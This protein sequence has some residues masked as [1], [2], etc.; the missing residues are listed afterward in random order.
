[1]N[2]IAIEIVQ[3]CLANKD[4]YL[5][6]GRLGLRDEDFVEGS[7]LDHLLRQCIHLETLVLSNEWDEW[8]TTKSK[9][10]QQ[11]SKN[12]GESNYFTT[13]PPALQTLKGLTGLI[14]AGNLNNRWAIVDM[15]FVAAL[16][17]L[18][19]LNLSYNQIMVI[20]GLDALTQLQSLYL[21]YNQIA[22]IR[23]LDAL[24]QLQ[25]L[26]LSSN[27]IADIKGL[28][29]L[30]QLQSLSLSSNG[31]TD[32]KGLEKLTQLQSLSLSS[33]GITDVKGLEKLTQLQSLYLSYNQITDIK[34]L[35]EPTQLQSLHLHNNQITDI[36]G[37]ASLT[38][39][40]S[41]SLYS[42]QITDIKGLEKLAQ[43]Q[44]LNLSYNQI[45]DIKGLENLTQLQLLYLHNN[46]ITNIKGLDTLTQ[47]QSLDLYSNQITDIKGLENLTQL[48]SLD[49]SYNQIIDI[50]GLEKLASLKELILS[51]NQITNIKGLDTLTQLQSLS[52][53]SNQITDI[54]G[55]EK[56]TQ[57]QSLSLSSNQI[58]DIMGLEKLTQL[59][60]LSLSSNQITDIK[61][62]DALTQLQSLGLSSNQITDIKGL[63]T[64]TALRSL[65]LSSNQIT[66]IRGLKKLPA[67]KELHLAYNQLTQSVALL[68]IPHL[69]RLS[70]I[71]NPLKDIPQELLVNQ[72]SGEDG[73]NDFHNWWAE[74][75]NGNNEPNQLAKL[76]L[77]GNG[78][79]GKSSLLEALA[80]GQCTTEHLSTNGIRILPLQYHNA[81]SDVFFYAWD[82]GGQEIYHGT[83]RLFIGSEAMQVIVTD[84][85]TEQCALQAQPVPDRILPDQL[86]QHLQLPHYI[87]LCQRYSRGSQLVVVQNKVDDGK[88]EK[89][90]PV[91]IIANKEG[92]AY[93][94]VSALHGNG[95]SILQTALAEARQ[96]LLHYGMVMPQSWLAVRDYFLANTS[97]LEFERIKQLRYTDFEAICNRFAVIQRST[98][99]LLKLLHHSGIVYTNKD[100][101]GDIIIT[102]HRW[103][104]DAI[105]APLDRGTEFYDAMMHD[106]KGRI[107]LKY[108]FRE[109]GD[110]YSISEKRLFLNFMQSCGLCFPLHESTTVEE[111]QYYI[112]PQFLP[113]KATP[114]IDTIWELAKKDIRTVFCTLPYLDYYRIQQFIIKLGHKT[115]LPYIWRE[116]ILVITKKG[117]FRVDADRRYKTIWVQGEHAALNHYL[118]DIIDAFNDDSYAHQPEWMEGGDMKS[119]SPLDLE[120]LKHQVSTSKR[121]TDNVAS[122]KIEQEI[123]NEQEE[124]VIKNPNRLDE[125]PNQNQQRPKR[126]VISYASEDRHVP[127]E[128]KSHADEYITNGKLELLFDKETED[129]KRNWHDR[130][131][132]IFDSAD[133]YL[134]LRSR[135]YQAAQQKKYIWQHEINKIE[136]RHQQEQIFTYCLCVQP[137]PNNERL[138]VFDKYN[139]GEVLPE[140]PGHKREQFLI[141]FVKQVI[142]QLFLGLKD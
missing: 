66:N 14:I 136:Q 65:Y 131:Q 1:M 120:T 126:L 134:I 33:N 103:A 106:W 100:L 20:Q 111:D 121:R 13:H 15:G 82:F 112:F 36:K 39:L 30:T 87:H 79:V 74:V 43:L 88:K 137:A 8:D 129:G 85:E 83:H 130:I 89:G 71:A 113:V 84:K 45:T 24:A 101:L 50:N 132:D 49:L 92:I 64:L 11:K 72:Y 94:P 81:N 42:N 59:Q 128:I 5:E 97:K 38:A 9:W 133:G 29:A 125:L 55:L 62:L 102:D 117:L 114:A 70:L 12:E 53:Y 138:D 18:Q 96:Q 95:I 116:G 86:V 52:L 21:Y 61:G 141:D 69:K 104:L 73:I 54:M 109:F 3:Q 28:D 37:L 78:N 91:E 77:I 68:Q 139:N 110:R 31:I 34:G 40:Q 16:P 35:E 4:P 76:Q 124:T 60:S 107:R 93:Y 26:D 41:L 58:T 2:P 63:D 122:P 142:G 99:S 56:L 135:P 119:A 25:S 23:G 80:K 48:Q 44:S 46:Q 6:L 118:L 108:L 67:L 115:D 32:V 22:D 123:V 127:A 98:P 17:L 51:Y 10:T 47:L 140:Q 57:L 75:S 90:N 105:Y 7:E 19:Q 27:Q